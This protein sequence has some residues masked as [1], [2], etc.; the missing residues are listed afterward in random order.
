MEN[1]MRNFRRNEWMEKRRELHEEKEESE[2]KKSGKENIK[3]RSGT[4]GK[5]KYSTRRLS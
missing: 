5:I 4:K 2:G 1:G 3:D